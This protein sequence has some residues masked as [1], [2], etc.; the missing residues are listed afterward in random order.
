MPDPEKLREQFDDALALLPAEAKTARDALRRVYSDIEAELEEAV[1]EGEDRTEEKAADMIADAVSDLR[2]SIERPVG[3][4]TWNI[5]DQR[6]FDRAM[7]KLFDDA[8]INP[9]AA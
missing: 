7:F 3:K 6:G 1:G 5:I 8:N 4:M 2:A 9:M